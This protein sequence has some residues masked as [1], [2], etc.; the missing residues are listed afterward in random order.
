MVG[1]CS[2]DPSGSSGL[3]FLEVRS[4]RK[5][6]NMRRVVSLWRSARWDCSCEPFSPRNKTLFTVLAKVSNWSSAVAM[7]P[8]D[9]SENARVSCWSAMPIS[10]SSSPSVSSD[11]PSLR[12]TFAMEHRRRRR[13]ITAAALSR[14]ESLA[15]PTVNI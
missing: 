7:G 8:H 6:R 3:G 15:A 2:A 4:D 12:S 5:A 11:D 14:G 13:R 9:P 10:R 1:P